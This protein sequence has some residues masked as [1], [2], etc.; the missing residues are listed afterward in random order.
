[1]TL[2]GF[3]HPIADPDDPQGRPRFPLA[4]LYRDRHP[5]CDRRKPQSMHT[6]RI[7]RQHGAKS[8]CSWSVADGMPI[9]LAEV[10]FKANKY[11][12]LTPG[13]LYVAIPPSGLDQLTGLS[14]FTQKYE[15]HQFR[16]AASI[17]CSV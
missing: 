15:E 17:F 3:H 4:G 5:Q 2:F 14:V 7:G 12:K 16:M 8:A 1:M 11:L 6:G 10:S 13:Y 9:A